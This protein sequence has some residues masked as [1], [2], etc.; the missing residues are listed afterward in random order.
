MRSD[1][2]VFLK[3]IIIIIFVYMFI[4][5][6]CDVLITFA[7]DGLVLYHCWYGILTD[8]LASVSEWAVV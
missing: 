3:I 1:R 7:R 2:G 4:A 6:G 8:V 5:M